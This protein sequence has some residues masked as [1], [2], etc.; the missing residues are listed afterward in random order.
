M[1]INKSKLFKNAWNLV[2]TTGC[3]ISTALK[4]AWSE[5]KNTDTVAE[6][7]IE[8]G[9][10]VWEKGNNKRIYINNL[11]KFVAENVAKM[12]KNVTVYYNV[13]DKKI[14]WQNSTSSRQH[15]IDEL[16]TAIK[17]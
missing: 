5:I 17:A 7:L 12:L 13:V 11:T 4:T 9:F 8:M 10:K 6:K 1:T 16:C 3:T 14:Y 15:M 2:K